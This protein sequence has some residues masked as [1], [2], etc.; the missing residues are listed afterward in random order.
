MLSGA[1]GR[2]LVGLVR[3]VILAIV[4]QGARTKIARCCF[5]QGAM[6]VSARALSVSCPHC[7]R[8]VSLA[9]LRIVGAHPGKTLATCG[10]IY[11]EA[12]AR[13]QVAVIGEKITVLGK[14]RGP[15]QASEWVE[16]GS[17]GHIIGDI[18][19]PKIVV[20]EG[21]VI[22]GRFTR[23]V[24]QSAPSSP[25]DASSPA[26]PVADNGA[27]N[28]EQAGASPIHEPTADSQPTTIK[29]RPLSRPQSMGGTNRRRG[30]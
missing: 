27:K 1:I 30:Q 23:L 19:A 29:P 25:D 24:K 7:R 8:V 21:G 17:T 2:Q 10:D 15:V 3:N 26:Q 20:R 16:V 22:H 5:C 6:R 4:F 28:A 13:L 12:T 9:D 11:I 14:V 18:T